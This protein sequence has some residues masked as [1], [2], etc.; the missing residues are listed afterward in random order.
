M[1]VHNERNFPQDK[2]D[3]ETNVPFLLNEYGDLYFLSY[4]GVHIIL[5]NFKRF[6]SDRKN[7]IGESVLKTVTLEC[8][9]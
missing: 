6:L 1:H 9:L 8:K 2:L 4:N 5:F 7:D 3:S